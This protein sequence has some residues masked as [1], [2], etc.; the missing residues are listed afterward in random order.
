MGL[1]LSMP[2][3]H[4]RVAVVSVI[5]STITTPGGPGGPAGRKGRCRTNMFETQSFRG[6]DT[7][8][9]GLS[10]STVMSSL[11]LFQLETLM[12]AAALAGKCSCVHMLTK[13]APCCNLC[14]N[15]QEHNMLSWLKCSSVQVVTDPLPRI[16]CWLQETKAFFLGF[17]RRFAAWLG[18]RPSCVLIQRNT[19]LPKSSE[20]NAY[21]N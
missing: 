15:T 17:W 14:T 16:S 12:D 13:P 6:V 19:C 2:R 20:V 18:G 11:R 4:D 9:S 5:S 8:E 7:K 3:V 1:W 10:G 21:C